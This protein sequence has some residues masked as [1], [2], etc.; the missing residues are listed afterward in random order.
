MN[1]N[2]LVKITLIVTAL[3]T[4]QAESLAQSG[5]SSETFTIAVIPD[6]QYY[7][8]ESHG[9]DG[10][11]FE[12]QIKW[13]IDNRDKENIVFVAHLGDVVNNGDKNEK[14]WQIAAKAMYQL[15]K[16]LP[17][18]PE[19]IPYGIAVGNHDQAK[20][21][22]P[23][24]GGT[25]YYNKYFGKNRF[26][27]RSYYGGSYG[28]NNDSHYALFS[29]NGHDFIVIFVEYDSFNE[30]QYNMNQWASELLTRYKDREAIIVSHFII[31]LNKTPGNNLD[32]GAEFGKQ[33]R[34]L[35]ETLKHH[36]NV[37]LMLCGHVGDHGEGFRHDAYK[38][39][40]IKTLLSDYQSRPRGGNGLL[41]LMTFDPKNDLVKVRTYS[42]LHN[43]FETDGDSQF[44][45]PWHHE[46]S[47]S[48]WADL[49]NDGKSEPFTY[50]KGVWSYVSDGEVHTFEYSGTGE[51]S[52]AVPGNYFGDG[53]A[54][55]ALYLPSNGIYE[56]E[57]LPS[58]YITKGNV[59][60]LPAD[61]NGDGITEVAVWDRDTVLWKIQG[62][63]HF[64]HGRAGDIP[65][66]ADYDGDGAVEPAIFRPSNH[67]WY[68][69][70]LGNVPFGAS[71]DYP[72]PGDYNGDG[73]AEMSVYRPSTQEWIFYGGKETVKFP[74]S[75][76]PVP[77][78]YDGDG[79]LSA[80]LYLPAEKVIILETGER[81]TIPENSS[82]NTLGNIP[83]HIRH[84]IAK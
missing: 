75:G 12:Q 82:V 61:Y 39:N 34:E 66:P 30:D 8:E 67:T 2:T 70:S 79:K 55:P 63:P 43:T 62:R 84:L 40:T 1:M 52:I 25:Y 76:I 57:G 47:T 48:R 49:N 78:D 74:T 46:V 68:I 27:S 17:G 59:I 37:S 15:E 24:S 3:L 80:A 19:G 28:D 7:S 11:I 53:K 4:F 35:Y 5:G 20:S 56:I 45:F 64:T 36:P 16:P 26:S 73:K 42:T 81:L 83:Y 33:G 6:T 77:G 18:F 65:V 29:A 58:V 22:F 71:E 41:R 23:L 69:L 72:L 60:P 50:E 32:R 51:G 54:S 21:Q 9:A 44:V 38:G 31:G 14:E 10:S 13:I